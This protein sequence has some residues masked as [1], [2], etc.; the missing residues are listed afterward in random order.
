LCCGV[1][2]CSVW[3]GPWT[4]ATT[5]CSA[6]LG[7]IAY[8]ISRTTPDTERATEL[9]ELSQDLADLVLP[10]PEPAPDT[11]PETVRKV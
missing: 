8:A 4:A 7:T 3:C 9:H 11:D 5:P 1:R 10:L 6:S 2:G